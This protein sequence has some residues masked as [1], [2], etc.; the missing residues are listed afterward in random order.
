MLSNCPKLLVTLCDCG[1]VV[2]TCTPFN[3]E[4]VLTD[5]EEEDICCN[6]DIVSACI[7]PKKKKKRKFI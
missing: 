3:G 6:L 2:G 5:E 1:C 7:F 4:G